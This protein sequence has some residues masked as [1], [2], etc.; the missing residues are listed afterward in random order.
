MRAIKFLMPHAHTHTY[1]G[2]HT[3]RT[4]PAPFACP[5]SKPYTLQWLC[6]MAAAYNLP[7]LAPVC[8]TPLLFSSPLLL[9]SSP[10]LYPSLSVSCQC[11]LHDLMRNFQ[12]F[13]NFSDNL[14]FLH[15]AAK[16]SLLAPAVST[17]SVC[18][19]PSSTP[20]S[21]YDLSASKNCDLSSLIDIQDFAWRGSK[22]RRG[23]VLLTT[24]A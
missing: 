11:F 22:V 18:P 8:L 21:L 4:V 3:V 6:T 14:S 19:L 12:N 15:Q 16:S 9:S 1:K 17:F 10:L 7:Q 2:T 13:A 5:Q 23:G 24:V 20:F